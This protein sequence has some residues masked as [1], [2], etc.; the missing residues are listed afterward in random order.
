MKT[1]LPLRACLI[2]ALCLLFVPQLRGY[3]PSSHL[4][5]VED[6]WNV[7]IEKNIPNARLAEKDLAFAA[8]AGALTPDIGYLL[9]QARPFTDWVHYVRSG[10]F[11]RTLVDLA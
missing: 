9:P 1:G 5:V 11:V 6:N 7:L 8:A 10:D 2:T 4:R 3:G